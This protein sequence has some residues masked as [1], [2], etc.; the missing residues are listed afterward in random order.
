MHL[1]HMYPKL[2]I[3]HMQAQKK[4]P[5]K[6]AK[7]TSPELT[8][9]FTGSFTGRGGGKNKMVVAVHPVGGSQTELGVPPNCTVPEFSEMVRKH[10]GLDA[11]S[12]VCCVGGVVMKSFMKLDDYRTAEDVVVVFI[13]PEPFVPKTQVRNERGTPCDREPCSSPPPP[14]KRPPKALLHGA[15]FECRR[16]FPTA[17]FRF[18]QTPLLKI[19][20]TLWIAKDAP[21]K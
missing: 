20:R 8:D 12:L 14:I 1:E 6:Q 3:K 4:P 11:G 9:S 16:E 10:L 19:R 17:S 18:L 21:R 15:R 5:D 2:C 13:M 7:C